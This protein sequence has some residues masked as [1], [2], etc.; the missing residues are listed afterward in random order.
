MRNSC[1]LPHTSHDFVYALWMEEIRL[2]LLISMGAGVLRL[3]LRY[4]WLARSIFF[5]AKQA[6]SFR[7]THDRQKSAEMRRLPGVFFQYAH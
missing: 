4:S 3:L 6:M 2:N 1:I 7:N 5:G